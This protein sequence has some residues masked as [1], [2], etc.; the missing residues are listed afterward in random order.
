MLE[1]RFA[2]AYVHL[3]SWH[4]TNMWTRGKIHG[5]IYNV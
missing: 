2:M 3:T 5:L 4:L 1:T